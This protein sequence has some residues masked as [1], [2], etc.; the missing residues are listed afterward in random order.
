M[1]K[2]YDPREFQRALDQRNEAART[3]AKDF[4]DDLASN[5][6]DPK[7]PVFNQGQ[8]VEEDTPK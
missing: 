7:S 3:A 4:A 2:K 8:S 1:R 6:L 5:R